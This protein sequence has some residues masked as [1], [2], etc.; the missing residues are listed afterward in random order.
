MKEWPVRQKI[1]LREGIEPQGIDV[2]THRCY[3]YTVSG[4]KASCGC[5]NRTDIV[6]YPFTGRIEL[7][8]NNVGC[9]VHK[10]SDSIVI[11]PTLKDFENFKQFLL[12]EK[13]PDVIYRKSSLLGDFSIKVKKQWINVVTTIRYIA[14]S[15]YMARYI[16]VQVLYYD[17]GLKFYYQNYPF[18]YLL[19]DRDFEDLNKELSRFELIPFFKPMVTI[20]KNHCFG[21]ENDMNV[22]KDTIMTIRKF[23]ENNGN[24][25]IDKINQRNRIAR[26]NI[27]FSYF[28]N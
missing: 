6:F 22:F 23:F 7:E 20:G 16:P 17:E 28:P 4:S 13:F 19:I 21:L 10:S 12:K 15:T 26:K 11:Q 3:R 2:D 9:P 1:V 24:E 8:E 25:L 27:K 14:S 5:V 18:A